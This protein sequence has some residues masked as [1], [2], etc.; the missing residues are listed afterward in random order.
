MAYD[1]IVVGAGSAGC[2]LASRLS[3]DPSVTVLLLEAGPP[4]TKREIGVPAAFS[5]LQKSE[6]DWAYYTT[7]QP[8]LEG[9]QIFWP[10]GRTLGGSSSIN[11]MIYM[12]GNPADYDGW[13]R[14]GNEGWSWP[15]VLPYFKRSEHNERIGG[16]LHGRGGPLNV[17][18]P[19]YRNPMTD[20]FIR[21]GESVGL[22]LNADFNGAGQEGIGAVQVTQK[23]GK[24]W[25]TASAFLKPVLHRKNLTVL[26]RALAHR[27]SIEQ[28]RAVGVEFKQGGVQRSERATREVILAGG[29]INSPQLL[30]LSGIGPAADLTGLG[31][32]PLLDLPGVGHNLQDHLTAGLFYAASKPVSLLNARSKR[33][34]VQYLLR[35]QGMLTSPVL[36][37]T[38]FVRS[39]P[40]LE[41]PDLQLGFGPVIY[42]PEGEL[43]EGVHGFSIGI[44]LLQPKSR[45]WLTLASADPAQ[46]PLI[47]P[48]YLTDPGGDDLKACLWGLDLVRRMAES[49]AFDEFRAERLEPAEGVSLEA[50]LRHR[51][52]TIYHPVGTCR[53][54]SDR[55]AVVDDQL[56]VRGIDGLR[57]VDA[58]VMPVVPR[59]NTNA[60]VI[61]IAEKASDLIRGHALR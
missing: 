23:G 18:D 2:V 25:S 6:V 59:G 5:D 52:S 11:A 44:F 56:R 60:P 41:A 34:L 4:D 21:S 50:H 43:P 57:V 26:T 15:E 48:R 47:E 17:A 40:E 10:R 58:S 32:Q 51:A 16:D 38:G 30:L 35:G 1:Y 7:P 49:A 46:A 55:L 9:R 22:P 42:D 54:G 33:A 19:R 24:R 28:Q 3:E 37:A 61:M 12:R 45:G 29:A 31:I 36:E 39:R 8:E 53:M 14:L 13:E 27:V 20:A